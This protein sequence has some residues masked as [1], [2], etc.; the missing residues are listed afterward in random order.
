MMVKPE[1][2]DKPKKRSK[3]LFDDDDFFVMKKKKSKTPVS[4]TE[5]VK[6]EAKQPD[7][8]DVKTEVEASE[9]AQLPSPPKAVPPPPPAPSQVADIPTSNDHLESFHT[10]QDSSDHEEILEVKSVTTVTDP[11]EVLSDD[12]S[13]EEF[14]AYIKAH[15]SSKQSDDESDRLYD[16]SVSSRLGP[17]EDY[18]ITCRGNQTFMEILDNIRLQASQ[19][20]YP[21]NLRGGC[22]VWI[23]GRSELK[24]FFR[25]STLRI[26]RPEDSQKNTVIQCLYIPQS[27]RHNFEKI[28]EE[29]WKTTDEQEND[30][31]EEDL[32]IVN[33]Q[34]DK[35][36]NEESQGAKN[37][38]FVIGLKGKDNKRIE[39]EV[40]PQTK[41]RALLQ[42]YLK[43]KDIDETS[44]KKARLVF[45]DED[46]DLDGVVADTELE[47][48]FELQVYI[49]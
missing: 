15:S 10:A 20:F 22:L 30:S 5:P 1:P 47:E 16:L 45:D 4:N 39:A 2:S 11:V 19:N 25:P 37:E 46:L 35:P 3:K 9:S 7:A 28:F 44:V 40:G 14:G 17:P 18:S 24:P 33:V 48:D 31:G 49:N 26:P 32:A 27:C 29:F 6:T 43:S 41:I 23:E 36:Q 13:D 42:H 8:E 34:E 21:F 12:D 38:Y